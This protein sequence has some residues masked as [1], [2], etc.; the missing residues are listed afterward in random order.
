MSASRTAKDDLSKFNHP[1]TN[2]F[3]SLGSSLFWCVS[4]DDLFELGRHFDEYKKLNETFVALDSARTTNESKL[5]DSSESE[6]CAD[7]VR[8]LIHQVRRIEGL[9]EEER[10]DLISCGDPNLSEVALSQKVTLL[11]QRILLCHFDILRLRSLLLL[12]YDRSLDGS[13]AHSTPF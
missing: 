12:E 2:Y 4:G 3:F 10:Q 5:P 8:H 6:Q 11:S 13:A 7:L 9:V 1:N